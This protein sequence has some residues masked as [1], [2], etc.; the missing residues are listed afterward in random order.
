MGLG[1]PTKYVYWFELF[2]ISIL[3]PN[4]SILGHLAGIL[5]GLAC[6]KSIIFFFD[7]NFFKQYAVIKGLLSPLVN[8]FNFHSFFTRIRSMS[9]NSNYDFYPR[10]ERE[11]IE[12]INLSNNEMD[13][14][15]MYISQEEIRQRRLQY[16]ESRNN[17]NNRF[18]NNRNLYNS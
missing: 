12:E 9:S 3:V 7:I 13:S 8:L 14:P 17:R 10:Q 5:V 6:M 1:I 18:S 2:L 11:N 15:S 16:L 4:S